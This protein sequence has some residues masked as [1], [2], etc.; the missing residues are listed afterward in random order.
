MSAVKK[1][2]ATDY[3]LMLCAPPYENIRCAEIRAIVFNKGVKENGGVFNHTQGWA[4][5]AEALLG[6]G[7]RAY[8]YFRSYLPAAMNDRADI[9]GI[10]PYVYS[11]Y[12]HSTYS[13]RYGASRVPW[14]TGAAS[15][16]YYAVTQFILGI[17]PEPDGLRIDPCIPAKWEGFTV[18][19]RF[20]GKSLKIRVVNPEGVQKG[21]KR[22][23]LN[24]KV[25][26][27]SL[28]PADKLKELNEVVVEMG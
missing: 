7:D 1:R 3:G 13:E 23:T 9:R 17:R 6:H 15:W 25:L 26:E 10:E 18:A 24:G 16:A 12:T 21:V 27:N 2:L 4:V 5:M 20:R 14:L 28:L 8:D 19:R 11:Q 22:V